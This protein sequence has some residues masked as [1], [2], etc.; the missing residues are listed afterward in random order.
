MTDLSIRNLLM[1]ALL[2]VT[3]MVVAYQIKA[4]TGKSMFDS[5]TGSRGRSKGLQAQ[6]APRKPVV[7]NGTRSEL[8]T[9]ISQ[10]LRFSQKNGLHIVAPGT[11]AHD[12][13][14]ARLT[15]LLVAPHGVIGVYCLGYGGTIT[16]AKLPDPWKQ[17][18]NDSDH[19][20]DNPVKICQEQHDLVAAALEAAGIQTDV[21]IAAVFT[22]PQAD[23]QS[24]PAGIYTRDR[25]FTYLGEF[26][27]AD[28]TG[29]PVIDPRAVSKT[30]A[31]LAG[32]K[33]RK[34]K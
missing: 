12:G 18:I 17:R 3:G 7:R 27:K 11:I 6:P 20:F 8:T 29:Q 26:A 21:K 15:A 23:L 31:D 24:A 1:A 10:L 13:Q 16:P 9:F 34:A 30:L 33:T 22:N 14:T 5:L 32:I 25:F 28:S 2:V 19:T 4:R